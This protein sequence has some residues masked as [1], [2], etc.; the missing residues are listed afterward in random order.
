MVTQRN[1]LRYGSPTP[2]PER[3]PLRAGPLSCAFVEGDLRDIALGGQ[4]ILRR[5]YVAVRD[6]QWGTVPAALRDLEILRRE[7]SFEITFLAEHR[8]GEIHFTWHGAFRGD[9]NGMLIL[10]MEGEALGAFWA[11]RIGFCVLHAETCAGARCTVEHT[12]GSVEGGY[13]P[14]DIS[15]HQP[16]FALRAISHEALPG[17]RLRVSFEGDTFEMEDQRN[18][19]DASFKIYSRPLALPYPYRLEPGERINQTVRVEVCGV[20]PQ[21]EAEAGG[22]TLLEIFPQCTGPLPALGFGITGEPPTGRMRERLGVLRPAHLRIELDL[23]AE[24]WA[25]R[26]EQAEA[27]GRALGVPLE[28]AVWIPVPWGEALGKLARAAAG[29]SLPVRRWLLYEGAS[30]A[31]PQGLAPLARRLLSPIAPGAEFAVGT[32]L[33]FTELNRAR[34]PLEGAEAVCWSLTPQVHAFDNAS[35]METLAIQGLIAQNARALYPQARRIVS[36][37]TLQPRSR[38]GGADARQPSLFTVAWTAGSIKYLAEAGVASI[39]YFEALG[40]RGLM[41]EGCVFPVYHVLARL[42]PWQGAEVL[43]VASSAPLRAV[44]LALR[45]DGESAALLANLTNAPQEVLL[46]PVGHPVRLERLNEVN[47]EAA[48]RDPEGN[49]P[50]EAFCAPTQ[51]GA[52]ALLLWPYEVVWVENPF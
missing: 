4:V 2:L 44:A 32:P 1:V 26:L 8:Q 45:R 21:A 49:W 43:P 29:R 6:A 52:L 33:H 12:D 27:W 16:F 38:V 5:I 10:R 34:P 31:T 47:A 19:S 14:K 17:V 39:T 23:A 24:E 25:Q 13:F 22:P 40:P 11:N 15:P 35:L 50:L 36:P 20:P 37:V 18:W 7:G 42:A 28:I 3:V 46:K 51:E 41:G 30:S 9:P 48:I